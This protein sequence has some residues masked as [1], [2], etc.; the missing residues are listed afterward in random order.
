[1]LISA[2]GLMASPK[3]YPPGD[4]KDGRPP[5]WDH[6]YEKAPGVADRDTP[7]QALKRYLEARV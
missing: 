3:S 2:T 7:E 5:D 1:M 4:F 6:A